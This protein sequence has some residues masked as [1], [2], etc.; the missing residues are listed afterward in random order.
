M[1]HNRPF[2]KRLARLALKLYPVCNLFCDLLPMKDEI[3]LESY[4]DLTCNTFEL[5]RYM[6]KQ[7]L[8]KK[9]K[10]TWLVNSPDK[11]KD[12]TEENVCFVAINPK[13]IINKI[14]L[15]IRTNRAA[16][17]I[18]SN[19]RIQRYRTSKKQLNI[20]LDH[21][22]QLKSMTIN[23]EKYSVYCD[24]IISQ[25]TFFNRYIMQEYG[26]KKEQIIVTGLPRN[27][28]LFRKN[29]S[30]SRIIPNVSEFKKTIIW[31]P[32]FRQHEKVTRVDC[33][34]N[35]P[36]GLPLIYSQDMI[37]ELNELLK[38][39]EVLLIVKPHP[40]QYLGAL[41]DFSGKYV[42]FIYNNDLAKNDIQTNELLSQTDAMITDYSGIYYDYLL[43]DRPIAISL[44]DYKEY[45]SQKGF[46]FDNPLDVLKGYYLYDIDDLMDFIRDVADGTDRTIQ[47]RK[48]IK[49]VID[50]YCDG[51]SSQRVF[52]FIMNKLEPQNGTSPELT[53]GNQ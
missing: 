7:E 51:N 53:E 21:A 34:S 9:Y 30:I 36:Y 46:V 14:K 48:K 23:G 50:E 18:A 15:Y 16:V 8:N 44:D 17:A 35:L 29:D 47:E 37:D 31:V 6:I 3:I 40:A 39:K 52:D 42:K 20:Y 43:L 24:Y 27:D 49:N 1:S 11:Y 2:K 28:Q 22:S 12:W 10:L 5:Y 13:G 41:K 19:R 32:T 38:E 25:S 4:P 33:V 26:V 45:S